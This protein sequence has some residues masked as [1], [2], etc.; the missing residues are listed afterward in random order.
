MLLQLAAPFGALRIHADTNHAI[1]APRIGR[2][3]SDGA[4][5]LVSP[6]EA[7]IIPD[8]YLAHSVEPAAGRR[9]GRPARAR[10]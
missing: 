9:V 7:P 3:R 10:R 6:I 5:D 8:P 2:A 1:L 4:F